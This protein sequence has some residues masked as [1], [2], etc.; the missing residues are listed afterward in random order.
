MDVLTGFRQHLQIERGASPRTVSAYLRD[1]AG[2]AA[3]SGTDLPPERLTADQWRLLLEDPEALR[4][5]LAEARRA[6]AARSSI[7]RRLSGL[8]AFARYL[9]LTGVLPVLPA[10]L[11]GGSVPGR[12][13]KLPRQLPVQTVLALLELPDTST[14]RGKRD[15]A[16]L[17]MIYGLGLRL[18]EVVGLDLGSLDLPGE[19][20]RV[21]GK[22][23]RERLLPLLGPVADALLDYLAVRL[24]GTTLLALRDGRL[25]GT[26]RRRPVFEG[27]PGRRIS[28]RTVQLRVHRY[29]SELAG[30]SGVSP[31]TLRHSFA[32]HLLD[33]GAGIR[34]VQELLGHAHLDTTRIYTHL[35]RARLREEFLKA[36]PRARRGGRDQ[37]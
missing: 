27:R 12:E 14:R 15:R 34:V 35:S 1:V 11:T 25:V 10:H 31:H 37:E 22:G 4:R 16:L 9:Q 23:D 17:E 29:A 24:D 13:R 5:C 19:Q 7:A 6:G 2:L 8:R 3:A 26:D 36:H 18:G 28:P 21:V 30:L 20:V 33:G 32:T